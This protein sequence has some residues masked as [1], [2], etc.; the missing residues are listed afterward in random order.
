MRFVGKQLRRCSLP[1]CEKTAEFMSQSKRVY[2]PL[3]AQY[4]VV[5][6]QLVREERELRE[7]LAEAREQDQVDELLD[8]DSWFNKHY[9]EEK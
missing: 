1:G 9:P 7:K 4:L 3:H 5:G 6:G 8:F 2:C